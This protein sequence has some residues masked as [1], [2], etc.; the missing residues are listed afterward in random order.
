[1]RNGAICTGVETAG[2]GLGDI[3][4]KGGETNIVVMSEAI[5]MC[6]ASAP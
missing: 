1:M 2:S 3:S 6:V 5:S 4:G